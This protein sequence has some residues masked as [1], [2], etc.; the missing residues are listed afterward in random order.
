[1]IDDPYV[2]D[3]TDFAPPL[4]WVDPVFGDE[5][6]DKC[7]YYFGP[8]KDNG[9]G[10]YNQVINGHQYLLQSEWSNALAADDGLGCVMNGSDRA[11][12]A[13]FTTSLK[14]P[15]MLGDASASSDADARD[16]V[17]GNGYLWLF[18]DGSSGRGPQVKHQYAS[19]GSYSV[20]LYVTDSFGATHI[21]TRTVKVTNPRPAPTHA[22]D[23]PTGFTYRVTGTYS[24]QGGRQVL[25]RDRRG[26]DHRDLHE[27]L[28]P[29]GRRLRPH[30]EGDD[31]GR[32]TSA[33]MAGAS[34][35]WSTP[36]AARR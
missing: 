22:F 14:G 12:V 27:Q 19:P 25:R 23:P 10:P 35:T 28:R 30:V 32:L 17:V 18:G 11:R 5:T 15:T 26:H 36:S 29:A 1:M 21:A 6:S 24:F 9:L 34:Q 13:A 16:S 7:A 31:R 33:R 4:A 3:A 2:G 20:S 8:T